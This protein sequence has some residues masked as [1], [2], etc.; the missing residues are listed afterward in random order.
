MSITDFSE[1]NPWWRRE[2]GLGEALREYEEATVKWDPRIRYT[3]DNSTDAVYT[4]R[5]PRQVGKTTLIKLNIRD[6]LHSGTEPR[7]IFYFDCENAVDTPREL[8]KILSTFLELPGLEAS[9]RKHVFID[10]ITRVRD[11]QSA[12][13]ALH[14]RGKL[15]DCTLVL[16]GSHA[17]D[18]AKATERLPGRRGQTDDPPDKIMVPMKFSEYAETLDKEIDE[19]FL[20]LLLRKEENR[21]RVLRALSRGKATKEVNELRYYEKKLASLLKDY[22]LTGGL[23]KVLNDY[24]AKGVVPE[25]T[26]RRYIDVVRGDLSRWGKREGYLRRVLARVLET[27]GTSVSWKNLGEGT[28]IGSHNTVMDYI[29]IL[30]DA[31]ILIYFYRLDSSKKT[32][33]FE[34]EKKIYFSDPFF[35]HAVSAWVSGGDP[36][37]ESLGFLRKKENESLLVEGVIANHMVRFAFNISKQKQLFDYEKTLHYWKSNNQREVDFVLNLNGGYMPIESKFKTKISKDD[38]YG[39]ADFAKATGT[40]SEII[41]SQN[42]FS[43]YKGGAIVPAWM[44]LTLI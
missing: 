1:Q 33:A 35:L 5:G 38:R 37:K 30:R 16:T 17:I 43:L 13:K 23:P 44:F 10:E 8:E 31:F 6:L 2:G 24:R 20:Q 40:K 4:L 27:T 22:L 11:W 42:E 12:I 7:N 15:K 34:K 9:K 21:R 28:D 14:D 32:S 29:D 19:M 41:V 39:L 36:F 18:V 3:F 26:Y 25:S